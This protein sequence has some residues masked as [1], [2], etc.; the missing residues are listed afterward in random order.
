M[1]SCVVRQA[2]KDQ[3]TDA[4]IGYELVIQEDRDSLYNPSSDSVAANTMVSFLSENSDRI[5]KDKK[6]FMT[7][8]PTLLF[9][10]TPKIFDKD[11]VVIQIGDNI[12][13]HSLAAILISKYRE[14]GYHFAINDF[15]FT[16]K[17]FSMLEYVDY[18][19]LDVTWMRRRS[20]LLPMLW[21]WLTDSRRSSL[22][23]A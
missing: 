13:I 6:T 23:Q 19:K 1:D 15:Q 21:I 9:R 5:F 18:I 10:N 17:Y 11:K 4:V 12:V 3:A 7:F 16:P 20:V 22:Q 2:I 14:D 8:T